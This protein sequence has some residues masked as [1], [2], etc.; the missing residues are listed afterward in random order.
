MNDSMKRRCEKIRKEMT[1][2]TQKKYDRALPL[3]EMLFDRW[4]KARLLGFGEKTSA[5]E[6]VYIYGKPKV[7]KNVWIGPLVVLDGSGGLNIGNGC[8]ISCGVMIFTHSTHLRCV[9]KGKMKILRKRVEIGNY[10]YIGSGAIILPGVSIG[11]HSV[12]GAGAVVTKEVPPYSI[13]GG[14]PAKVLK[15]RE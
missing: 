14:V 8:D 13:V 6:N 15:I 9:S 3:D 4:K 5:Y 7:G 11:D 10:V 2:A 12:V 1:K